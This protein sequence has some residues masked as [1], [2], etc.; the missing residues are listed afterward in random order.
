MIGRGPLLFAWRSRPKWSQHD[1]RICLRFDLSGLPTANVEKVTLQLTAAPSKVGF[2]SKSADTTFAA[3]GILDDTLDNRSLDELSWQELPGIIDDEASAVRLLGRFTIP[4]G[5][6]F[7][8]FVVEG[9]ELTEL[10]RSETNQLVSIVLASETE[11]TKG[12]L[13]HAFAGSDHETLRAP[14]LRLWFEN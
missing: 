8:T 7:G 10:V 2:A 12:M 9:H 4:K 3:Y 14:T 5:Q 6:Q 1:R 11:A 13:M